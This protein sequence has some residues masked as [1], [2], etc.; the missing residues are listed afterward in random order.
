VGHANADGRSRA[1][2]IRTRAGSFAEAADTTAAA[3]TARVQRT[4]RHELDGFGA[5]VHRSK[6]AALS[7]W[8]RR[9]REL[10][11]VTLPAAEFLHRFQTSMGGALGIGCGGGAQEGRGSSNPVDLRKSMTDAHQRNGARLRP[12]WRAGR[13]TLQNKLENVRTSGCWRGCLPGR[14][15]AT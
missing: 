12:G 1:R 3:F 2:I 14:N 15:R 6:E 10:A 8:T 5:E 4:G 13:G 7:I 11:H 9:V